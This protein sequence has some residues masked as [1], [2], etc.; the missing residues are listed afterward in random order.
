MYAS[1]S[2]VVNFIHEMFIDVSSCYVVPSC[3]VVQIDRVSIYQ[4]NLSNYGNVYKLLFNKNHWYVP[5]CPFP[6]RIMDI[7]PCEI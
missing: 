7:S 5:F 3:R 2:H 1:K 4:L 6:E